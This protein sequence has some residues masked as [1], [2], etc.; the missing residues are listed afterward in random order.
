MRTDEH[1]HPW[2]RGTLSLLSIDHIICPLHL[3]SKFLSSSP[4]DDVH[5]IMFRF[6]PPF[7]M[8]Y[9]FLPIHRQSAHFLPQSGGISLKNAS[10]SF[11]LNISLLHWWHLPIHCL[12]CLTYCHLLIQHGLTF[13]LFLWIL[14]QHSFPS[15]LLPPVPRLGQP[16]KICQL[17]L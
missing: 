17:L 5:L 7:A 14:W 8:I 6:L 10:L 15:L 2:K 11:I 4:L 13:Y 9:H 1:T 3:L 12:H 16:V